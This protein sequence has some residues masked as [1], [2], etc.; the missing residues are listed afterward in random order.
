[1]KSNGQTKREEVSLPAL[2]RMKGY[3]PNDLLKNVF[4]FFKK[5]KKKF[6]VLVSIGSMLMLMAFFK[7]KKRV[8][9]ST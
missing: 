8:L 3:L 5:K 4:F 7:K 2:K 9:A 6:R 1:L